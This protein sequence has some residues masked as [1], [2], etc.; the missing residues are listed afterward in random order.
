[1]ELV[2]PVLLA[3]LQYS[4]LQQPLHRELGLVAGSP[5]RFC[6]KLLRETHVLQD[7]HVGALCPRCRG[8]GLLSVANE[9]SLVL[10]NLLGL[11]LEQTIC[12][13]FSFSLC[14]AFSSR[15][16]LELEYSL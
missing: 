14:W 13:A 2:V 15:K 10:G 11:F 9:H 16:R 3:G 4:L 5:E 8:H 6:A 12:W 7:A 1:M